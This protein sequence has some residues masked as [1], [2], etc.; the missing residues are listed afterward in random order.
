MV[1]RATGTLVNITESHTKKCIMLVPLVGS[2][3]KDWTVAATAYTDPF[4][5]DRDANVKITITR[6]D[7]KRRKFKIIV[8]KED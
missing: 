6:R 4:R 1:S 2:S 3:T 8:F 5:K 7:G